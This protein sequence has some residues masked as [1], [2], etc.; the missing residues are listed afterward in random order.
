MRHFW[1][2]LQVLVVSLALLGTLCLAYLLVLR[3]N[4]RWDVT[5]ERLYSLSQETLKLLD[6]MKGHPIEILAFYSIKDPQRE[7]FEIFLR[8]AAERHGSLTYYFY[9]PNKHPQL[10]K[11]WHVT[12]VYTVI[13]Q[14]QGREE[15][16]FLP[17]E[18]DFTN[19]LARLVGPKDS[20]ACFVLEPDDPRYGSE[21]AEGF[22]AFQATLRDYH[23]TAEPVPLSGKQAPESCD[24][25]LVPGPQSDW[26]KDEI[27]FLRSFFEAGKPVLFMLDPMERKEGSSFL[28]L[29][30]SF[31][32]IAGTNV[33]VDRVSRMLG[34]DF[35]LPVV[36]QYHA[37]HPA[38]KGFERLSFFPVTR[39]IEPS[40]S[41][42]DGLRVE[43]LAWT[44]DQSW[45]ETDMKKLE[46]GEANFEEG[47]DLKG[48]LPIAASVVASGPSEKRM[49][50]IGDSDFITNAY[51]HLA[52][53]RDFAVRL[54][55]WLVGQERIPLVK[56]KNAQFQ[57]LEI[58]SGRR[59]RLLWTVLVGYPGFFLVFGL[60]QRLLRRRF[61]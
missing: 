51:L 23:F 22:A 49:V 53:N 21:A 39:S 18:E 48:P 3:F 8:E 54:M 24:L 59:A 29:L 32:L 16:I 1:N 58:S 61:L 57:P 27:G 5:P 17:D 12:E 35:L 43:A 13:L 44:G 52:G 41:V 31:G 2:R 47:R 4:H 38:L 30:K 14:Y 33:I 40:A 11:R 60:L 46:N 19:A 7:D 6:Q 10:A 36:E 20:T 50:V 9:E 42:P 45:A 15:R 25:I 34:G 28:D 37:E 55:R 26:A 56:G